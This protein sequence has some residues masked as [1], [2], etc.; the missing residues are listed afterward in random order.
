[1]RRRDDGKELQKRCIHLVRPLLLDPV[2]AVRQQ[3]APG[4]ERH[5]L[6]Q[7]LDRRAV[8]LQGAIFRAAQE[9]PAP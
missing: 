2:A 4:Q 5:G 1:V 8:E 9:A 7:G 6:R 3:H